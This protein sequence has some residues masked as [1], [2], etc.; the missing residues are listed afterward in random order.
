[1]LDKG[2]NVDNLNFYTKRESLSVKNP[3]FPSIPLFSGVFLFFYLQ[4]DCYPSP[5]GAPSFSICINES[6]ITKLCEYKIKFNVFVVNMI[7]FISNIYNQEM[8]FTCLWQ[9]NFKGI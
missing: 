8:T 9:A 4:P 3:P 6:I 1:M 7:H 2:S 5:L